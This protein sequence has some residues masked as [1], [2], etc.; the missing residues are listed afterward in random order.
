MQ[1]AYYERTGPARSVLTVGEQPTPEPGPGEVR[2]RV[3]VS[4]VN[5]SDVKGRMA[6]R[7]PG[8]PLVIPHSAGA[9]V[10]DAVGQGVEPSRI[11]ERVWLWNAQWRRP[12]GTAAGYAAL[13]SEQAVPLPDGVP[14]D[15]GACLGI[16]W[17]TAWRAVNYRPPASPGETMLV[18]GGAG[19]VGCY[20]VQLAKRAGYRVIAT[21]SSDEKA[22]VAAGAGAD[23]VLNYRT[24][25]LA[26]AVKALTDGRGVDRIVE[27]DLAANCPSYTGLLAR[28]GLVVAYGSGDWSKP[29][30]LLD[31]LR[32]GVELALFSVYELPGEVRDAA[33]TA[34]RGVLAD[35]GFRHLV[36]ARFPLGRIV[37]A[38]EA[39][40]GGSLIGNVLV[41]VG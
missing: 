14:F 22:D 7:R 3:V 6:P 18:A 29:L 21:V 41:E 27:V 24:G 23:A 38:H 28:G 2:V 16:P 11:G 39:V 17:F 30:P 34:S 9:G 25:D 19:S 12:F 33:I 4:G 36:A 26:S 10:V 40:E 20:A 31:W 35:P 15:V 5:P 13:P 8:F 37:E 32:H 1:A